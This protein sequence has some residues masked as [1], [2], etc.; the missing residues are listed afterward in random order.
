M[1]IKIKGKGLIKID[2]KKVA[3]LKA[4]NDYVV[5]H[6][7]D[8]DDI[9]VRMTLKEVEDL[10]EEDYFYRVH[11]SFLVNLN[12]VSHIKSNIIL[13]KDAEIPISRAKRNDLIEALT[14]F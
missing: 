9:R 5:M 2:T 8:E 10:I 7:I 1:F 13:L 6:L 3:Y 4:D 11:R 12:Y 14:L